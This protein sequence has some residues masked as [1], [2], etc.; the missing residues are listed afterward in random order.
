MILKYRYLRLVNTVGFRWRNRKTHYWYYVPHFS[1]VGFLNHK[2][3][4]YTTP[5]FKTAF[6]SFMDIKGRIDFYYYRGKQILFTFLNHKPY[7]PAIG[8]VFEVTETWQFKNKTHKDIHR[9]RVTHYERTLPFPAPPSKNA[10]IQ[11]RI[12]Y[13]IMERMDE[14][15]RKAPREWC[16][17]EQADKIHGAGVAGIIIAPSM[18][19]VVGSVKRSWKKEHLEDAIK[20]ANAWAGKRIW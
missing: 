8:E 13:D 2:P 5:R 15:K 1:P 6:N 9:Y 7:I 10:T 16:L 3:Y 19:K 11:Q 18:V 20:S 14:G 17:R 4:V 12:A